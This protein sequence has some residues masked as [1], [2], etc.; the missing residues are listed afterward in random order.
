MS[1]TDGN[2]RDMTAEETEHYRP[3]HS[4]ESLWQVMVDGQWLT[5]DTVMETERPDGSRYIKKDPLLARR[6]PQVPI[7]KDTTYGMGLM[8][9]TKYGIPVVQHGGDLIGY[10]SQI[11]FNPERAFEIFVLDRPVEESG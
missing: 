7:G 8:V 1:S 10:H 4:I 9:D 3:A 6:A 5:V 2:I 11:V